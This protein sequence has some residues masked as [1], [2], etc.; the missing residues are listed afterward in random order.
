MSVGE[1]IKQLRKGNGLTQQ[2]FADRI[3]IQ[4]G[5]IGKYEVGVSEP[6]DAAI[7]L[8][9]REF[10]VS[11]SWLR[12]GEG[13]MI[14]PMDREQEIAEYVGRIL[15]DPEADF[16][17]RLIHCM[18]QLTPDEMVVLERILDKLTEK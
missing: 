3:H 8:I 11:E 10:G 13:E 15:G 1:R 14:V 7:N 12:T 6:S 16:Q 18:S 17:R 2:E 9:C 4:R 5:N